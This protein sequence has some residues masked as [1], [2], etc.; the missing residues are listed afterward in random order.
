MSCTSLRVW[1]TTHLP[2]SPSAARARCALRP[3]GL[4]VSTPH[5]R[6][7]A[8]HWRFHSML[9]YDHLGR[10]AFLHRTVCACACLLGASG[11][12]AVRPCLL[13]PPC[14]PGQQ[15]RRVNAHLHTHARTHAHT[16]IP[17]THTHTAGSCT[18]FE[19]WN[20]VLQ[21]PPLL[22]VLSGPLPNRCARAWLSRRPS[23]PPAQPASPLPPCPRAQRMT[24]LLPP[25]RHARLCAPTNALAPRARQV[26]RELHGQPQRRAD[27]RHSRVG[28]A[29]SG[30]R[31]LP[32]TRAALRALCTQHAGRQQRQQQ[33]VCD[34]GGSGGSSSSSSSSSRRRRTR[35]GG[36]GRLPAVS[37]PGVPAGG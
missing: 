2:V 31:Q 15:L 7:Q 14:G 27:A 1:R 35:R 32:A 36:A 21:L 5:T 13:P 28:H 9:Q 6:A 24:P 8:A 30:L 29:A 22:D 33:A 34:S 37:V 11:C 3:E 19:K 18:Q 26:R 23:C 4:R 25:R 16:H 20:N 17:H 12:V 10:P